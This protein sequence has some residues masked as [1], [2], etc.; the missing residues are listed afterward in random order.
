MR[1]RNRTGLK[2]NFRRTAHG[3]QN[4]KKYAAHLGPKGSPCVFLKIFSLRVGG[5]RDPCD[6]P[7]KKNRMGSGSTI[8]GAMR[9]PHL[10]PIEVKS[11]KKLFSH[12][13]VGARSTVAHLRKKPKKGLNQTLRS[14]ATHGSWTKPFYI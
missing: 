11:T 7:Y 6:L 2:K 4:S 13:D 3:L 9:I 12:L 8:T 14:S 5:L 10:G 1:L